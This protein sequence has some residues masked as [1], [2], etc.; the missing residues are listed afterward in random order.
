LDKFP[1]ATGEEIY[2]ISVMTNRGVSPCWEATAKRKSVF[3]EANPSG[4]KRKGG[5]R[6]HGVPLEEAGS[7]WESELVD[8][9]ARNIVEPSHD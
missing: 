8:S 4:G 1:S 3:I 6:F 9:K 5:E 7:G 2:D